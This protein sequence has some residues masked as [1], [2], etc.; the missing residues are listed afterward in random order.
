MGKVLERGS[1][2]ASCLFPGTTESVAGPSEVLHFLLVFDSVVWAFPA[3]YHNRSEAMSSL[4][5][6]GGSSLSPSP[7]KGSLTNRPAEMRRTPSK[8]QIVILVKHAH[9]CLYF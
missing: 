3:V 7:M 8:C 6:V 1:Q 4:T 5:S 2:S 9:L